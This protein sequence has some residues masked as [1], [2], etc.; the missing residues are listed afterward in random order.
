MA[1]AG[2]YNSAH[3]KALRAQAL[4]R[5]RHICTTPGCGA[6]AF[7]VDHIKTRP[8]GVLTPTALDV[9]SNLRSV[10][11]RCDQQAK[12]RPGGKRKAMRAIGCDASG[13]PRD[14]G[15]HWK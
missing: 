13:E 7:I 5:D 11:K 9:L 10:C 15:H 8:R 3:W 6:R 2:Y 1:A 14:P 12:E 4:K